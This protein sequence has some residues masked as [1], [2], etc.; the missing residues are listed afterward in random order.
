[1]HGSVLYIED[2][3]FFA[4]TISAKLKEHGFDVDTAPTG[5]AGF[6]AVTNKHYDLVLL[7]LILPETGG[8]EILERIKASPE[9]NAI[10]VAVLSNLS[11]E[12]DK[13]KAHELGAA[14]FFVKINTTPNEILAFVR[15]LLADAKA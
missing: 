2:E 15:R 8:F 5:E 14:G 4:N 10:P 13:K 11:S 7:D 12:S 3:A 9:L 6:A 1:M